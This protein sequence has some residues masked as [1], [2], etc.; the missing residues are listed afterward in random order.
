[1]I[2]LLALLAADIDD[3][4][5]LP[6]TPRRA[7]LKPSRTQTCVSA[8]CCIRVPPARQPTEAGP[9]RRKRRFTTW[10]S[11]FRR[12]APEIDSF[13]LLTEPRRGTDR[14]GVN[15]AHF[16]APEQGSAVVY[17]TS[18]RLPCGRT[19]TG[20]LGGAH[21]CQPRRYSPDIVATRVVFD[22]LA[23]VRYRPARIRRPNCPRSKS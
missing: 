15:T 9:P 16:L 18:P 21:A 1:M 17:G 22:G 3:F 23:A 11:R 5:E 20:R 19:D 14:R 6:M 12:G 10:G 2:L 8:R 4:D 13:Q 7:P